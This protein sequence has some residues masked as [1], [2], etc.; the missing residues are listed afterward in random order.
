ML[1]RVLEA[2]PRIE[3]VGFA[4]N[5]RRAL[6]KLD[7]VKPDVL[8]LD[9]EMPEMDGLETLTALRTRGHDLPVIMFSTL[10]SRGGAATL[11]ALSRG[12]SDYVAKPSNVGSL[13]EAIEVVR[14]Q[15]VPKILAL[16]GAAA[17]PER[18]PVTPVAPVAPVARPARLPAAPRR[19]APTVDVVGIGTST[20]GPNALAE[21]LGRLSAD[22][23]VP[24]VV[25]QHMPPVFTRIL[26]ER[27]DSHCALTVQEAR[28]ATPLRP[29]HAYIAPGDFH[30]EVRGRHRP[31]LHLHQGEPENSCRPA[32]DVLFRSLA[33]TY[34]ENVLAVV[35]TGMGKDGLAGCEELARA[36]ASILAQDEASSVVWGMPGYVTR[37]GLAGEVLPL[38]RIGFEIDRRV[39]RATVS[40]GTTK[41]LEGVG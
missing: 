25:V 3:V 34:G 29:G 31:I 21:V 2:E 14:A 20:G 17:G 39:K 15:L 11:E 12:A 13:D 8:I 4:N 41:P 10:T 33:R 22:L 36:G 7:R 32:V 23:P 16:S 35:M 28:Q 24:V 1:V 37:A 6:E 9:V 19:V 5:G 40:R 26:S 18:P 27:L 30:L 38:N